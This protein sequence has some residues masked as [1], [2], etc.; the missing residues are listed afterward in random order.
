MPPPRAR[1]RP[2]DSLGP[3]IEIPPD[4]PFKFPRMDYMEIQED[5]SQTNISMSKEMMRNPSPDDVRRIFDH[6]IEDVR[7]KKPEDMAQPAF[8]CL[9]VLD[10]QELFEGGI[11]NLHYLR[12]IQ[13]IF[14]A[15]Q[16]NEFSIRDIH[17]PEKSR[18]HWQLCA[19]LNFA[20]FRCTRL[21][22]FEQMA[23]NA[24][25]LI[26]R[27]RNL[28]EEKTQLEREIGKIEQ[29]RV[30][31]EPERE[32]IRKEVN[33]ALVDMDALHK[34]QQQLAEKTR[35]VKTDLERKT[36]K[37]ATLKMRK[38]TLRQE[39]EAMRTRI[40]SSPTRVM[41]ELAEMSTNVEAEKENIGSIEKR[42]RTLKMRTDGLKKA[43]H[44]VDIAKKSIEDSLVQQKRLQAVKSE[45]QERLTNTAQHQAEVKSIE[46]SRAHL[47]RLIESVET[48]LTRIGEQQNEIDSQTSE[49]DRRLNERRENFAIE[50]EKID[51]LVDQKVTE[52][53]KI[54]KEIEECVNTF[55]AEVATVIEKQELVNQ[56]FAKIDSDMRVTLSII[57]EENER[58]YKECKKAVPSVV[59]N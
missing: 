19:L 1:G 38:M 4:A 12:E 54:E 35:E 58:A 28:I 24:E 13:K 7:G 37:A 53:A 45:I 47:Q 27:E 57:T 8:G 3:G 16:F 36:E 40:V 49:N 29:A 18:F 15:A 17:S 5:M 59:T 2:G 26:E 44:K 25:E 31:E 50:K 48:K 30:A 34:E 51:E 46:N 9:E 21:A 23:N 55:S 6:F 39:V 56:K 33:M 42:T 32:R 41:G 52:T 20:K 10:Y 43:Y 14:R 11:P 22:I